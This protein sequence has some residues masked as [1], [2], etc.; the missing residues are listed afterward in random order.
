VDTEIILP[1]IDEHS[2]PAPGVKGRIIRGLGGVGSI[3]MDQGE[4]W[5]QTLGHVVNI[6]DFGAI[7]NNPARASNNFYAIQRALN[8]SKAVM[9]PASGIFYYDQTLN[10]AV[11]S[12]LFGFGFNSVLSFRGGNSGATAMQEVSRPRNSSNIKLVNFRLISDVTTCDVGL[13]LLDTY[14]VTIEGVTIGGINSRGFSKAGLWLDTLADGNPELAQNSAAIRIDKCEIQQADGHGILISGNGGVGGVYVTGCRIQANSGWGIYIECQPGA[15]IVADGNVIEG[16]ALGEFFGLTLD[17]ASITNNHFESSASNTATPIVLGVDANRYSAVSNTTFE[18]NG[19]AGIASPYLLKADGAGGHN[20]LR[21]I[22]NSFINVAEGKRN[23][24][25]YAIGIR[26]GT[27][28]SILDNDIQR[29]YDDNHLCDFL[30]DVTALVS[31]RS[32]VH[33]AGGRSPNAVKP[34][35]AIDGA[36]TV[37]EGATIGVGTAI[38]DFLHGQ[39]TFNNSAT[40][41]VSFSALPDADYH[42]VVTGNV[43][44]LFW[45]TEKTPTGFV[46]H[47]NNANSIAISDWTLSR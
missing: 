25:H 10:L 35:L 43:P 44:E 33:L 19:V 32:Q 41:M 36:L 4:Q 39:A 16:N 11:D 14:H 38:R 18:N 22:N 26:A 8:Q 47:S 1:N 13:R 31:H 23:P 28:I 45:I 17:N 2:L 6:E 46:I 37:H 21:I 27:G 9:I 20:G 24:T 3:W 29:F 7:A 42:A 15:Q 30:G 34:N 12:T 5:F 40:T